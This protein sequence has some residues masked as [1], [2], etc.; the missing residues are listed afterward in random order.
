MD[1]ERINIYN[2]TKFELGSK[3]RNKRFRF[4]R[5]TGDNYSEIVSYIHEV[6]P[7]T[8]IWPEEVLAIGTLYNYSGRDFRM[9]YVDEIGIRAVIVN[10]PFIIINEEWIPLALDNKQAEQYLEK[11]VYNC[12]FRPNK[13]FS[14]YKKDSG[15]KCVIEYNPNEHPKG[16]DFVNLQPNV[17]YYIC[18]AALEKC[19][20]YSYR[21][22][23]DYHELQFSP[24]ISLMVENIEKL[25]YEI[26]ACSVSV[27]NCEFFTL[28]W[29]NWKKR[30]IMSKRCL[31]PEHFK[32]IVEVIHSAL[33]EETQE[34]GVLG[35]RLVNHKLNNHDF[36]QDTKELMSCSFNG[37]TSTECQQRLFLKYLNNS[38]GPYC[39]NDYQKLQIGLYEDYIS[40]LEDIS[41]KTRKAKEGRIQEDDEGKLFCCD[42]E[43]SAIFSLFKGCKCK[44]TQYEENCVNKEAYKYFCKII[45][46]VCINRKGVVELNKKGSKVILNFLVPDNFD[47]KVGDNVT[48][49]EVR[50]DIH[51][52][53]GLYDGVVLNLKKEEDGDKTFTD[54]PVF[55]YIKVKDAHKL[56]RFLHEF[57][58]KKKDCKTRILTI[59]AASMLSLISKDLTYSPYNMEFP[60]MFG[61]KSNWSKYMSP[62]L[63]PDDCLDIT[64]LVAELNRHNLS[65]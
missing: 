41:A 24:I 17:E 30:E 36:I 27:R 40:F 7:N 54:S 64:D 32:S 20:S 15:R 5:Y 1:F 33:L 49:T 43:I 12:V 61:G 11:N 59:R 55:K 42:V 37:V 39:P 47:V 58:P 22:D 38:D 14:T 19:D 9:N 48:V 10:N 13:P 63:Y 8:E 23:E 34:N 26:N 57:L 21:F 60:K 35:K 31:K 56:L 3:T 53:R 25:K 50:P 45:D 6:S 2:L 44:I 28:S 46:S 52:K 16:L 62:K 65:S 18:D 29:D 4:I 51:N